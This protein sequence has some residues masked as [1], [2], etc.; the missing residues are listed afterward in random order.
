M[1]PE[2]ADRGP[3]TLHVTGECEFPSG[4]FTLELRR[5][6]PQGFNPRDKQEA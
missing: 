5:H 6:E 1:E 4:G 3:P 2:T